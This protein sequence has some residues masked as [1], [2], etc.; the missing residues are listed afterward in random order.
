MKHTEGKVKIDTTYDK[1]NG[2]F[3]TEIA[4]KE[5]PSYTPFW[6][7]GITKGESI[8]NAERIAALWNASEGMS[9]EDAVKALENYEEVKILLNLL[10]ISDMIHPSLK[11][12][13]H[14]VLVKL[15]GE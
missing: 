5:A 4:S 14:R 8:A 1:D 12:D 15:E 9:N 7:H 3:T 10:S 11:L 2:V 13:V 6:I